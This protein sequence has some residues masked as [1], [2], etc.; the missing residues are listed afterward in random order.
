MFADPKKLLTPLISLSLHS[1]SAT[2]FSS[3][4]LKFTTRSFRVWP[5][6]M[7]SFRAAAAILLLAAPLDASNAKGAA[8]LQENKDVEGVTTLPSGLQYK[9]IQAATNMSSPTP[10]ASTPC[11]CHYE[12]RTIDGKV[13]Y[14]YSLIRDLGATHL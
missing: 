13:I 12:G 5:A 14:I 2:L 10:S 3:C 4:T 6:T 11:E 7:R 9:V 8:F 1:P